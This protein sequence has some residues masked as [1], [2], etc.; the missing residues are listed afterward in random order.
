MALRVLLADNSETI[1]KVMN[2]ALQD[3]GIEVKTVGSGLDVLEVAKSFKPE[4]I[5][6]DVLLQK[7][8]GYEV[9]AELKSASE[10]Q[11]L[12]IVLMWSSFMELDEEKATQCNPN[13]R[14]E[15]PFDSEKLRAI[16]TDLVPRLKENEI[17]NFIQPPPT[18]T[19]DAPSAPIAPKAPE[20]PSSGPP[21]ISNIPPPTFSSEDLI[22]EE[23]K[24][25]GAPPPE[26]QTAITPPPAIAQPQEQQATVEPPPTQEEETSAPPP[27][28]DPSTETKANWNMDSF[29]DIKDFEAGLPELGGDDADEHFQN[30][31]LS[32]L[33]EEKVEPR[34]EVSTEG[35]SGFEVDIPDDDFDG[36][37]V[38]FTEPE[39][40][41]SDLS[42]L[43]MGG[44]KKTE[45]E[46]KKKEEKPKETQTPP[47][48]GLGPQSGNLSE[49]DQ[50]QIFEE[51][52]KRYVKENIPEIATKIIREEIEK[53]LASENE[54]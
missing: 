22:T 36:V 17:S 46:T 4:I 21:P 26:P 37:T 3:F 11:T 50:R 20:S 42:F 2:L 15:K 13:T 35:A 28:N 5:F 14:L 9:C 47:Q 10:T 27:A 29:Q 51:T 30:V 53:L 44:E 34:V 6:V 48:P 7:K 33:P 18:P 45:P 31:P 38:N 19:Q 41:I 43:N 39:E 52:V 32:S 25:S 54:S 1:K 12:P 49:E 40:E 8:N 24:P 23:A 16:V